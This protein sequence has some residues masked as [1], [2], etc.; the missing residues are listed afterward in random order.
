MDTKKRKGNCG[1][2]EKRRVPKQGSSIV[3]SSWKQVIQ[4]FQAVIVRRNWGAKPLSCTLL[5]HPFRSS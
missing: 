2:K 4:Y 3:K 5:R 1:K